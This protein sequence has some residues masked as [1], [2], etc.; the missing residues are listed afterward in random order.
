MGR[1]TS[2]RKISLHHPRDF[3]PS[4]KS[5]HSCT[6]DL[7]SS[8]FSF[9]PSSSSFF[10]SF[11]FSLQLLSSSTFS[12]FSDRILLYGQQAECE[13]DEEEDLDHHHHHDDDSSPPH[14]RLYVQEERDETERSM[15][16]GL[17]EDKFDLTEMRHR[18]L[19]THLSLTY[20]KTQLTGEV[21]VTR[22]RKPVS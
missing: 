1:P 2:M 15:I 5:T 21:P 22:R 6:D 19:V 3:P 13:D 12:S 16:D 10:S 4:A 18:Y 8:S 20:S 17:L 14:N 7:S 9:S 11:I